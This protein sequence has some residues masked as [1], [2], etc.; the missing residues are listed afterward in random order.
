[1]FAESWETKSKFPPNLKPLLAALSLQ[2][3]TLDEYDDNFFNLMPTIF[4]YNKFTMS[5]R[6]PPLFSY[7]S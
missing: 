4:P 1:M 6:P 7:S 3:I 5:V 2:A